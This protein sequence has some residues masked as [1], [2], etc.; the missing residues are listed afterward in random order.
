MATEAKANANSAEHD[1]IIFFINRFISFSVVSAIDRRLATLCFN[2]MTLVI[3]LRCR[4]SE[5]IANESN[6]IF[7]LADIDARASIQQEKSAGLSEAEDLRCSSF[8]LM[9]GSCVPVAGSG[10]NIAGA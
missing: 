1:T 3:T 2:D 4:K 9:P 10:R 6:E 7:T 5:S 8:R